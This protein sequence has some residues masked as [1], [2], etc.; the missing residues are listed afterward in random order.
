MSNSNSTLA[1]EE[2]KKYVTYD[3]ETGLIRWFVKRHPN[4]NP[5]DIAGTN[6]KKGYIRICVNRKLYLAHVLAWIYVY[7]EHPMYQ[8]DHINGVKSDNRLVNL[9]SVTPSE[10]SQNKKKARADSSSGLIGAL[11]NG[12]GWHAKICTNGVSRY[13]GRF[14]TAKEAS[15]AY[16]E[17]K[18]K[19]HI[20]CGI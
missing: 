8:I 5:G 18:K 9:R 3:P 12:K 14:R 15:D 10:N 7:G 2:I 6:T 17:E 19:V 11:K 20:G 16:L 13:L 4:K 1:Q